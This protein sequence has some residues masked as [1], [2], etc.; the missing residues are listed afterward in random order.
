MCG[1]SRFWASSGSSN[2]R[3][4]DRSRD[5]GRVTRVDITSGAVKKASHAPKKEKEVDLL[6]TLNNVSGFT[7]L[8]LECVCVDVS[9]NP[10]NLIGIAAIPGLPVTYKKEK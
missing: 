10:W 5:R 3:Q 8:L 7:V 6:G 2:G 9:V 4:D 1:R